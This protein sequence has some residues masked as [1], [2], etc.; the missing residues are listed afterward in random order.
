MSEQAPPAGHDGFR[1]GHIPPAPV[2]PAQQK[3]L[4]EAEK[5]ALPRLIQDQGGV[6]RACGF[7]AGRALRGYRA[8][9]PPNAPWV[10]VCPLCLA[11]LDWSRAPRAARLV[12]LPELSP[13]TVS[14]TQHSLFSVMYGPNEDKADTADLLF[15]QIQARGRDLET[16]FGYFEATPEMVCE[17][18]WG[19]SEAE[20]AGA[21]RLVERMRVVIPPQ[22]L[23]R[24]LEYWRAKVYPQWRQGRGQ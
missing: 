21:P 5:Q 19:L 17:A 8:P 14:L 12:Y 20:R 13:A 3:A 9:E 1:W 22:E 2:E 23:G 4:F 7:P 11:A 6:C 15:D 10:G 18:Y 24:A 16:L